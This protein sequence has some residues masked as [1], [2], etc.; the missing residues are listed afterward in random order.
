MSTQDG[1]WGE[2]W[3]FISTCNESLEIYVNAWLENTLYEPLE[4]PD[5]DGVFDVWFHN[6]LYHS[7]A[8][9][10]AF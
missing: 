1:G 7:K 6:F 2:P 10:T 9:Y 5:D 4:S 8:D 3:T